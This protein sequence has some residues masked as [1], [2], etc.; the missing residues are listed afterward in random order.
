MTWSQGPGLLVDV[1]STADDR[2]TIRLAGDF[3]IMLAA[4]GR[5]VIN[6]LDSAGHTLTADM[7]RVS[8]LDAAGA[9]FLTEEQERAKAAGGDLVVS[10]PSRPV[11]R[12]LELLSM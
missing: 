8:F 4:V 3:D 12:V 7:S 9:R 10:Y 6:R 11:R 2:T 5:N 1:I